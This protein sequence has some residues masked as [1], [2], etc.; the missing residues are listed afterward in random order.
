MAFISS[1]A[2]WLLKKRLHQIDLFIE[3]PYDVQHEL[4]QDLIY[5][6]RDTEWGNKYT[7][8]SI[9]NL[10]DFQAR[11]PISTYEDISPYIE[12]LMQG[13]HNLLWPSETRWFAKSSGTTA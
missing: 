1:V 4:F 10:Q 11:V 13:E 8:S 6:A 2:S 12:R 7:Y 9:N 3:Y 5:K